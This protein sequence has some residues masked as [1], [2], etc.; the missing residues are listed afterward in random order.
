MFCMWS[1]VRERK[2]RKG[3]ETHKHFETYQ[4]NWTSSEK[5]WMPIF[6]HE[7]RDAENNHNSVCEVMFEK[8]NKG[9]GLR[10]T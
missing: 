8:Q 6:H 1:N 3:C 2:Q 10:N 5:A 4:E 7:N 9:R